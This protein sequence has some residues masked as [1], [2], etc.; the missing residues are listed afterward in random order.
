MPRLLPSPP[1]A[2]LVL[3]LI[4][5]VHAESFLNASTADAA[6]AYEDGPDT[7]SRQRATETNI[8]AGRQ[9]TGGAF[10]QAVVFPFQLPDFGA[11]PQPFTNAE[12]IFRLAGKDSVSG[13]NLDLYGLPSRTSS[14]VLPS[15]PSTTNRGDFFMGG[16]LGGPAND[17]ASGVVKIQDNIATP[18]TSAGTVQTNIAGASQLATFLNAQYNNGAGA[19][20][21]IFLRLSTDAV[22]G[23]ASRYN[24]AT[25]EQST[26]ENRPRIRY[27]FTE[28]LY[29]RIGTDPTFQQL[30]DNGTI[31]PGVSSAP[32][33][34][35]GSTIAVNHPLLEQRTG[36][37]GPIAQDIRI[38]TQ[39]NSSVLRSNFGNFTRWYQEDGNVQVMRLFQGEQN[40]QVLHLNAGLLFNF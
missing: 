8:L 33:P 31:V 40:I 19:G 23:G 7:F 28:E 6:A 15:P 4:C 5:P 32:G 37:T 11:V 12:F 13:F 26:P 29:T 21:W 9:G 3:C 17:N 10:H 39:V 18:T 16:F 22:P 34:V 36:P 14:G 25:A 35:P 30:I 2:V 38:H 24:I 1:L 20:R 27:N